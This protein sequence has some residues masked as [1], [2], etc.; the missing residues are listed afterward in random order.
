MITDT[1]RDT[2]AGSQTGEVE[3]ARRGLDA[4]CRGSRDAQWS[5]HRARIAT[6]FA[7]G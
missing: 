5:R 4:D 7:V 3:G 1:N 2:I 6:L